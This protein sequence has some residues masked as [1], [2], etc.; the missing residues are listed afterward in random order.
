M[1]MSICKLL[2]QVSADARRHYQGE[3]IRNTNCLVTPNSYILG[4]NVFWAEINTK[5]L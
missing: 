4:S 2:K 3:H 1:F 5:C